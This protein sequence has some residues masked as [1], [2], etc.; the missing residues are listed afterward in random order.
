[1]AQYAFGRATA[2]RLGVEFY[3]DIEGLEKSKF[4]K[5][6]TTRDF[7]LN[8][9]DIRISGIADKALKEKLI[10]KN[11]F[12]RIIQRFQP[13]HK[14]TYVTEVS[15]NVYPCF[16]ENYL[17]VSSNTYLEGYWI[18][19]RYFDKNLKALR[20]EFVL[21]ENLEEKNLKLYHKILETKSVAVHVR[22]GDFVGNPRFVLPSDAYYDN[23]IQRLL[24]IEPNAHFFFF[25]DDCDWVKENLKYEN[26]Y[27]IDH[28]SNNPE[29]D[30][31]LMSKAQHN[32]IANSTFSWWAAILNENENKIVIAPEQWYT[33][34]N[35]QKNLE[36]IISDL[37]SQIL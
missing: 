1:M 16:S 21:K 9:F 13:K 37:R 17:K 14:H 31:F 12:D 30:I 34:K 25:S 29:I 7:Q 24:K 2:D 4:N 3:L 8:R 33:N 23:A 35:R 36:F 19:Q 26:S 20:R 28:N 11:F 22:R 6:I 32:I 18:N 10:R 27:F 5:R 15:H